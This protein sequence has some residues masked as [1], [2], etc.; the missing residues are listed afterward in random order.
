MAT[1]KQVTLPRDDRGNDPNDLRDDE[2]FLERL[3]PAAKMKPNM[4]WVNGFVLSEE[5][6]D[7]IADPEWIY[8]NLIIQGHVIAVPAPPN[9]GKTTIFT[10]I[11]G[12]ISRDWQVLYVNA[13]VSGGDAKS[14]ITDA[15]ANGYEMLL[16]DMKVGRS[17]EDVVRQLEEMNMVDADYSRIVF[18][19]DTLKKMTDVINKSKSKQLLKTLRGLSAKGMTIVLLAHTNKYNDA[20]GKPI[21]EGTGDLRADVDEL[22]YL[23]PK[24]NEDGS[25]TVSTDPD[26]IRGAFQP[27]T[28]TITADRQVT[29]CAEFVDVAAV[30][31][32]DQQREKDETIIEAIR[33][34]ILAGKYKQT[35]IVQHCKETYNIG[36]RTVNA[37]LSRYKNQLWK[38]DKSFQNNAWMYHL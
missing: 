18:M 24:K 30:K 1:I 25:M 29:P 34:A 12:Q 10:W 32:A 35:E 13:D 38:R 4:N 37:V 3:K 7:M 27:I 36:W 9:G 19:F 2:H 23:I 22:I 8:P 17:M 5:E 31:Q 15:K 14:M 28:F 11:A 26:K 16:P 33:E 6:A 21:Y 20:D